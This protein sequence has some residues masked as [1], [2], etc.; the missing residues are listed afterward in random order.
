M[1]HPC[2][3]V[4]DE[5]VDAGLHSWDD[6][7]AALAAPSVATDELARRRA[8][9]ELAGRLLVQLDRID[10]HVLA[11]DSVSA[12]LALEALSN[13]ALDDARGERSADVG[14]LLLG[15]AEHAIESAYALADDDGT[16]LA[17][18]ARTRRAVLATTRLAA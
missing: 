8:R 5:N 15:I 16:G 2:R 12:V 14:L 17:R 1:R 9:A 3:R 4:D 6:V 13:Q 10:G 18:L 11:H 7:A